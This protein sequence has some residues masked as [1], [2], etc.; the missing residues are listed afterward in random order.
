MLHTALTVPFTGLTFPHEFSQP[1]VRNLHSLQAPRLL[2]CVSLSIIAKSPHYCLTV[3]DASAIS[4]LS[5]HSL[6]ILGSTIL[7]LQNEWRS[8]AF[9]ALLKNNVARETGEIA[10]ISEWQLDLCCGMLLLEGKQGQNND[11]K[12]WGSAWLSKPL[13]QNYKLNKFPAWHP[14]ASN[15]L[16]IICAAAFPLS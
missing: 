8:Q 3:I 13:I 5:I 4:F 7:G 2:F 6:Y 14:P 12:G 10:L 11:T 1:A 16:S 15:L 9:I